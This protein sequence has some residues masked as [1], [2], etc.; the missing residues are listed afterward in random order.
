MKLI[1]M[2]KPV[3]SFNGN[4]GHIKIITLWRTVYNLTK[5]TNLA[6]IIGVT[7]FAITSMLLI[8]FISHK[9]EANNVTNVLL[10]NQ[11]STKK[12]RYVGELV[13]FARTRTRL[14][15]QILDSDDLFEKDGINQR[16]EHYA[17]SYAGKYKQLKA[18]SL[19]DAE[20]EKLHTQ[21]KIVSVILPAQRK[22]VEL[23]MRGD[24]E[25][26]VQA[27]KIYY[28]T[29][30]PG[31]NQ[32]ILSFQN[33]IEKQH[34]QIEKTTIKIVKSLYET[35]QSLM[36]L[37]TVILFLIMVIAVLVTKKVKVIQ[38]ELERSRDE[39]EQK[40]SVRT[41]ELMLS[42]DEA[43]SANH[44]K[45]EFLSCMSHELR[46]PLT[47]ILGFSQIL[48]Y[49]N[50]LKSEQ[51]D[52]IQEIIKAGHH[53]LEL[54]NGILDLTKI[55]SGHVDISLEPVQL[56][57]LVSES[58]SLATPMSEEYGITITAA[59]M[60]GC[61]VLAD[62]IK[63]KQILLNLLTNSIKYNREQGKVRI[64]IDTAGKNTLRLIVSDT[65]HGIADEKIEDLFQPF[66]RLDA[67]N[68]KIEGTGIGLA[69]T[70][71]L[72]EMMGG[73]I[74]VD[75]DT[76]TGSNFWVELPVI[77]PQP[78]VHDS[79]NFSDILVDNI[80][81]NKQTFTILYIED[82][83]TNLRL[84]S[85]ILSS[86]EKIKLITAQDQELGLKMAFSHLPDL[87][88][89]DINIPDL[90]SYQ[91]LDV[92]QMDKKLMDIP[93]LAVTTKVT[94]RDIERGKNTGFTDYLTKPFNIPLFLTTI[95]KYLN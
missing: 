93:V 63:L 76:G 82:N 62:R 91:I 40:V 78:D 88:L 54:I 14:T 66:N 8:L 45:S 24:D 84:V 29:V 15:S 30:L 53:L 55:E 34:K 13:E 77:G 46:T 7:L 68:S 64:H 57:V 22:S 50:S 70:R 16:L 83:Q 12:M 43:E 21:D 33:M 86:H 36:L 32:L 35:K 27:K 95:D 20:E 37:A 94:Q 92:L 3:T 6:V 17:G 89:L 81:T 87:I 38:S 5:T 2:T 59:E 28:E 51:Q 67:V 9:S 31:Q 90:N 10:D 25:S 74:G 80:E 73:Q 1:S 72:V 44:A 69:I 52:S 39:L 18:L 48:E 47:A 85:Q 19:S 4:I 11:L 42:R 61:I 41:N 65:G 26:L 49:D 60:D 75:S 79:K 58:I 71:H 23:A 56:D